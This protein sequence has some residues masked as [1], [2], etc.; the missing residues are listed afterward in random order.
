GSVGP[1]L[2]TVIVKVTFDPTVTV[3]LLAILAT[4]MSARETT[5]VR[6][7]AVSFAVFTSPPP[8]T[9]PVLVT[10]LAADWSTFTVIEIAGNDPLPATTA[11]LVHVAVCATI[12]HVQP[13][14]EPAV[15]VSPA[16][17]VSV[18]VVVPLVA[19]PP[20]L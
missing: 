20:S 15:G 7:V 5:L 6:S 4:A 19:V 13:A 17:S 12:A 9:V 1:L 10:A 16:G 2:V 11:V 18:T 3:P 8:E 14:P